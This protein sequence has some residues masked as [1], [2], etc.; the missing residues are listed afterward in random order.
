M[1]DSAD[2]GPNSPT[3]Q[4]VARAGRR[5]FGSGWEAG[6]RVAFFAVL[7]L[8][9]LV[10]LSMV[11]GVVAERAATKA[12]VVEEIG[13]QWGPSQI[14]SGPVLVVP[15][16]T[17][18]IEVVDGAPKTVFE[19]RYAVFT[20]EELHIAAK[21][22]VEKRYKSIY[23]V[24][25]YGADLAISGKFAAPDVA[26]LGVTSSQVKWDA[27]SLVLGLTGVR[28]INAV[29]L[30]A[31]DKDREIEA[32]VLPYHPFVDGIRA[33]LPL[34]ASNGGPQAFEFAFKLALNGRDM[35]AFQPLGRQSTITV[36]SDWP[37]PNFT[38]SPLPAKREIGADGFAAS[39]SISHIATGSPL[40]WLTHEYKLQPERA[41]TVGVALAEPGDVHQQTDRIV[42]Y[43]ILVIGLTFGTMFVVGTLKRD[44][45]HLVQYLLIGAS[46][47]LFYLL[48][49]S[50][51]EQMDFA[52]SYLIASLVDIAIVA[53]YAG[54][55]IRR[56]MG[57]ITGA[58]L[59]L[60]HGYMYVLLQMES[61]SLL[62]GTIGLLMALVGVMI[63]TRKVDW[64]ALGEMQG[65]PQ[66]TA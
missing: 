48:L 32:G 40:S 17:S 15:Y 51:A 8:I 60:V 23:E 12:Q 11:E 64:F 10:P 28:A 4:S 18:R 2:P 42:K 62:S 5:K 19:T 61:L 29:S 21:S 58:I 36:A 56:L 39:W 43:G 7:V 24:L 47:T 13:A 52:L 26:L 6:K 63:A 44:R 14:I 57:W 55:T 35:L 31:A 50:L 65:E 1:S 20:P 16:E 59:A 54:A 22:D 9:M 30:H 41:T 46:I 3:I 37:H 25:V 66:E 53:W 38:G 27:A 34:D 49:L 45:V 33:A